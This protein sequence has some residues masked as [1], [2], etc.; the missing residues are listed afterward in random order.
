MD[1]TTQ[2]L[3]EIDRLHQIIAKVGL[4]EAI[5]WG[6]TI[7][8]YQERN[9]VACGGFK[10]FFSLWFY[11]GVFLSDP[12]KV[13]VNA[14]EG[15]TKALRQWRFSSMEE[16]EE[17][18][19]LLYIKEAMRNVEEGRIWVPQKSEAVSLPEQLQEALQQDA[20]FLAAFE[21]LT[22]YKQKEYAEYITTAKRAETKLSRIEKMKP[23]VSQGVGLHD[24]YKNN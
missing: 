17:Q 6:S 21:A 10:H 2:W 22:P 14:G 3:A 4:S 18:K 15:K 19:I 9:V 8:T 16:I 1:T 12:Y 23:L 7:Y 13:L 5:K 24:K 20:L 11:D